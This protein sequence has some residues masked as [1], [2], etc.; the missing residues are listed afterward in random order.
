MVK[1]RGACGGSTIDGGGDS[2]TAAHPVRKRR[3]AGGGMLWRCFAVCLLLVVAASAVPLELS[4][5]ADEEEA[6]QP[7]DA[8]EPD[9]PG[10]E[11]S[12]EASGEAAGGASSEIASFLTESL[13]ELGHMFFGTPSNE[14]ELQ[15]SASDVEVGSATG[16]KVSSW[17][18]ESGHNPEEVGEYFQGDIIQP[19][20]RNGIRAK[21]ARW[22]HGVVHYQISPGFS[23]EAMAN[24]KGAMRAYHKLTCV[25]FRPYTG[26]ET[27]YIYI[28]HGNT[29]CWSSVGRLGGA[30]EVNLQ[31]PGCTGTLGTPAHELMHALGFLHEQNRYERDKY[32]T[33]N[34]QNIEPGRELNFKKST[35]EETFAYGVKYD[36]NS[37]MHYS[38]NAFSINGQPTIVPAAKLG[39]RKGLS[40]GDLRKINGMYKKECQKR[41]SSK[42]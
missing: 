3:R 20:S 16:K 7:V 33:I 11:E 28:T 25:R 19:M 4:G 37:V 31:D 14:T 17:S 1:R 6:V 36:Y 39:Q 29:G 18:S 12:G 38:A 30:Q 9:P 13:T 42:A 21:G 5:L 40:K 24:I 26:R 34:W 27:D 2:S 23:D 8:G 22:P 15:H 41:K 35:K 32:V 10:A